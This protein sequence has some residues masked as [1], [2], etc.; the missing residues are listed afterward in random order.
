MVAFSSIAKDAKIRDVALEEIQFARL[1]SS[2]YFIKIATI[3]MI[4]IK[5]NLKLA[6][7]I[8]ALKRERIKRL[9][10]KGNVIRYIFYKKRLRL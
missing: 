3:P 1:L 2:K 10:L 6:D 5:W 9:D 8:V 7:S 4:T